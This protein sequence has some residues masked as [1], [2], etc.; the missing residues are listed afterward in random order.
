MPASNLVLIKNV[1]DPVERA[2]VAAFVAVGGSTILA[3]SKADADEVWISPAFTLGPATGH[4]YKRPD[5][6]WDY[7]LFSDC[8]IE[9]QGECLR[10]PETPHEV[11]A[12]TY[13][14]FTREMARIALAM[15]PSRWAAINAELP[16]HK[17]TKLIPAGES[18]GFDAERGQDRFTLRYTCHL[19]VRPDAWP[20]AGAGYTQITI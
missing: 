3:R 18:K 20:A 15:D 5:G 8:Q 12:G 6:N 14:L 17:L 2:L 1:A 7:D 10:H 13:S 4:L 11:V 16:Y 9:W 19:G